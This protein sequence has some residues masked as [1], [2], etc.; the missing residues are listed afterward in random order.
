MAL[1]ILNA[2]FADSCKL[3]IT[4]A[5]LTQYAFTLNMEMGVLIQSRQLADQVKRQIE[6]LIEQGI[7]TLA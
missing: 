6:K 5:N 1:C 3:F 2:R 7:L 4:S